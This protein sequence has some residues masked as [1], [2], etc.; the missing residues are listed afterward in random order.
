VADLPEKPPQA[1]YGKNNFQGLFPL[2][3]GLEI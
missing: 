1:L 2:K 3:N